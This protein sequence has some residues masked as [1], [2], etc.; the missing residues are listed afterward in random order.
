MTFPLWNL[1][2]MEMKR[3]KKDVEEKSQEEE[4]VVGILIKKI[5]I[6]NRLKSNLSKPEN[7]HLIFLSIIEKSY[8]LDLI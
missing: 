3:E 5:K 4:K 8:Y 1:E 7:K 6:A 2:W